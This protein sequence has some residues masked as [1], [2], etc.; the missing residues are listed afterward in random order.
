MKP[1]DINLILITNDIL[2]YIRYLC[3]VAFFTLVLRD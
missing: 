2:L 3:G 1:Q